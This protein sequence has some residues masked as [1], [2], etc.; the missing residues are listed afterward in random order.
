[1]VFLSKGESN[2]MKINEKFRKIL[3]VIF[4]NDDNPIEAGLGFLKGILFFLLVC[5]VFVIPTDFSIENMV[6]N[7]LINFI[8]VFVLFFAIIVLIFGLS[9]L[10]GSADNFESFFSNMNYFLGMSL[11]IV[12]VPAFILAVIITSIIENSVVSLALF[13]LIP[14][15]TYVLFGWLC[16]KISG[17]NGWRAS[18]FAIISMT[19]IFLFHYSLK[20]FTV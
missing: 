11:V 4:F 6:I 8:K 12:S 5:F 1:M 16:E 17:L 13:S 2:N 18:L 19:M 14:F 15:Y 7:T 9:K 20:F 3:K 10:F